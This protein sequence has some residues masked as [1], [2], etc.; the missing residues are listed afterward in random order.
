MIVERLCIV[1]GVSYAVRANENTKL[2]KLFAQAHAERTL[3]WQLTEETFGLPNGLGSEVVTAQELSPFDSHVVLR[4]Q[5]TYSR[6]FG[7]TT[8]DELVRLRCMMSLALTKVDEGWKAWVKETY[9][10]N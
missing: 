5:S 4:R 6:S 10:A 7:N 8:G 9:P 2:S 3:E 1:F